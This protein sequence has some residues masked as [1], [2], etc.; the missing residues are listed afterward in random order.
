MASPSLSTSWA[1]PKALPSATAMP[2]TARTTSSTLSS[3]GG[4]P[5]KPG[6]NSASAWTMMSV[7]AK[8]SAKRSSN[9]ALIVS[10]K[11]KV[12]ATNATPIMIDSPVSS[13]RSQW[14]RSDLR[15]ALTTAH[16]ELLH[17]VEDRL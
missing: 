3:T 5:A 15:V 10:V 9:V 14:A 16:L 2:S 12:P 11:T 7:P 17:P 4:G 6:A 1:K 8:L 13:R